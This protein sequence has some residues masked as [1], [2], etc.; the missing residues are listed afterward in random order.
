MNEQQTQEEQKIS[1]QLS[2]RKILIPIILGLGVATYL[3]V[4]SLNQVHF[5]ELGEGLGEY[6]WVDSNGDGAPNLSETEEFIE[7]AGGP[8]SRM[9]ATQLLKQQPWGWHATLAMLAA[10]LMVVIRD[11]GY[12]YRI[13]VLTDKFL[14]W[15]KAFDV[16]M[17]W[18]FASALT[19]SVVGGSGVAIFILN[20]EGINLGKST[21]TVFVTALMDEMFY[22]ITVPIIFLWVGSASLFPDSWTEGL[23]IFDSAQPFFYLGYGFILF[24]TTAITLSLFFFPHAF[25][26][27]LVTIFSIK[28]LRRWRRRAV[29]VG[30]EIVISSKE[31]K[32]KRFGYWSKAFLATLFSWTARFFTFNFVLMAFVPVFDHLEVYGRQLVMWVILLIGV[33]PGSS[34]IAE[35]AVSHFFDYL[36][37]SGVILTAI[38]II[39]RFLTYFPYLFIGAFILP[40]WLRRTS[41]SASSA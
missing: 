32:G 37:T 31:L 20:R 24:L 11:F 3:L 39:W 41:R 9:T 30:D 19:P 10:I 21:A 34:G 6:A 23:W 15:R 8:Y 40:R 38:A 5:V 28:F 25:K 4:D 1:Q 14:S 22:I 12:M 36:V 29:S 2:W 17:L 33:T 27:I 35:F 13:R 16:V 18:E 7:E 26:R